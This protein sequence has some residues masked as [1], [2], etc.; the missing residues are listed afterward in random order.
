MKEV[1]LAL[2]VGAT[3]TLPAHWTLYVSALVPE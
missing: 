2:A 1:G 3:H